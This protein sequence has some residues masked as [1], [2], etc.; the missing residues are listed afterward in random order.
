MSKNATFY[1]P[2]E[3]IVRLGNAE[4][5]TKLKKSTLVEMALSD[6]LNKLEKKG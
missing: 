6:F 2:D 4:K 5:N 1:L 3:L